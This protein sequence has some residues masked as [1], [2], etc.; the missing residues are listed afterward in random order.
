MM[1]MMKKMLTMKMKLM[2]KDTNSSPF[3]QL[4]SPLPPCGFTV[5]FQFLC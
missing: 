5:N 4:P 3:P 2:M 1:K